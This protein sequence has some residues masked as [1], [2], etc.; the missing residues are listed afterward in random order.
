MEFNSGYV[1]DQDINYY[2]YGQY[3]KLLELNDDKKMVVL[4]SGLW[5][6]VVAWYLYGN[7]LSDD[8][9]LRYYDIF[10]LRCGLYAADGRVWISEKYRIPAG[11]YGLWFLFVPAEFIWVFGQGLWKKYIV[12]NYRAGFH[13]LQ[14]SA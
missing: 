2:S 14:R 5:E 6:A 1:V 7:K 4:R 10:H 8:L 9:E 12:Y 11:G 3:D 13:H